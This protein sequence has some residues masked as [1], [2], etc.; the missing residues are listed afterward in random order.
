VCLEDIDLRA[1]VLDM[2]FK[3]E[4]VRPLLPNYYVPP[5]DAEAQWEILQNIR[6]EL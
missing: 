3:N 4:Q 2:V 5:N 6:G 1:I